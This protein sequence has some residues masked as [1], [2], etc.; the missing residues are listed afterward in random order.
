LQFCIS[1]IELGNAVPQAFLL[2]TSGLFVH[3][4]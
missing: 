4:I 2:F 3:H 1:V